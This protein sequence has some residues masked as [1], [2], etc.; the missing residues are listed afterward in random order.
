MNELFKRAGPIALMCACVVFLAASQTS[1]I[2]VID[3]FDDGTFLITQSDSAGSVSSTDTGTMIGGERETT[4]TWSTPA[5]NTGYTDTAK[6]VATT[7]KLIWEQGDSIKGSLVLLYDG[8]GTADAGNDGLDDEDLTTGGMTAFVIDV[9]VGGGDGSTFDVTIEVTSGIGEGAPKTQS[10]S[11]QFS[12]FGTKWL[13]HAGLSGDAGFDITNVDAIKYTFDSTWGGI[14]K[15]TGGGDYTFDLLASSVPEPVTM[16]G[17][18]LGLGSV[19]AY[20]RRR[21]MS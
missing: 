5:S 10:V 7:S 16:L 14:P 18:F 21:R 8:V 15:G 13:P 4:L 11:G 2:V 17:M 9:V 6:V 1:A 3:D 20:I 19:G 12:G